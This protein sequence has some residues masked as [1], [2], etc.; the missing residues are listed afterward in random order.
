M[1]L[2]INQGKQDTTQDNKFNP[3]TE[4][5]VLAQITE[6]KLA[7]TQTNTLEISMRLLNGANKGRFVFDRVSYDPN[8]DFSWKYRAIRKAAGCPY[9]ENESAQVD[10]EKLLLNKAVTVDL[11]IRK[12]KNKDGVEQEYQNITYKALKQQAPANPAPA[13]AAPT[14]PTTPVATPANEDT[15]VSAPVQEPSVPNLTDDTD[16]D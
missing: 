15:S 6:I 2:I 16:W 4:K 10:I 5:N 3:I 8:S 7:T 9:D 1:A 14:Q 12:G 11:G 13:Q